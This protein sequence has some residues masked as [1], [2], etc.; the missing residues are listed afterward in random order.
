M[1]QLI[2]HSYVFLAWTGSWSSHD[3]IGAVFFCCLWL[4]TLGFG[5]YSA[6]VAPSI[7]TVVISMIV[8]IFCGKN[9]GRVALNVV[10]AIDLVVNGLAFMLPILGV[11]GVAF[12]GYFFFGL[13]DNLC[14]YW[15]YFFP[16]G[17]YLFSDTSI[18]LHAYAVLGYLAWTYY[19]I[20]DR[21]EVTDAIAEHIPAVKEK[22]CKLVMKS[23]RWLVEKWNLYSPVVIDKGTIIFERII[24]QARVFGRLHIEV[25]RHC[26]MQLGLNALSSN[27]S[28]SRQCSEHVLVSMKHHIDEHKEYV[29]SHWNKSRCFTLSFYIGV[30][31]IVL[32]LICREMP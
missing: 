9:A 29:K 20:L 6:F 12:I 14:R 7:L 27:K 11:A 18:P 23:G 13:G 24:K 22:S 10:D 3:G 28:K 19:S 1:L 26:A 32:F 25:A 16:D 31:L 5:L 21:F 30:I 2:L 8:R 17:G 15:P 4:V